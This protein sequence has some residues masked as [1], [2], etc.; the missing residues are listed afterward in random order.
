MALFLD[1][2]TDD[3]LRVGS[4]SIQLVYKS[5]RRARLRI[6]GDAEVELVRAD[7]RPAPKEPQDDGR[8]AQ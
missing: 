7:R 3:E 8:A 6:E 5:G 4:T 1:V 2:G